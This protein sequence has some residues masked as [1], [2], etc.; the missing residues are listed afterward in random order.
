[1]DSG[2]SLAKIMESA[3]MGK[4]S[5]LSI[6]GFVLDSSVRECFVLDSF[7]PQFFEVDYQMVAL[8]GDNSG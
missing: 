1:M 2:V 4:K 8:L 7:V 5:S 6:F 3:E